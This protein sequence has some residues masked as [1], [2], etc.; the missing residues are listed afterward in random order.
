M[1][2]FLLRGMLEESDYPYLA[3]YEEEWIDAHGDTKSFDEMGKIHLQNCYRMLKKQ[4]RA[5]ERGFF[6]KGIAY[7]ESQYDEIVSM[8]TALYNKKVKE[9]VEYLKITD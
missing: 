5:I 9:L 2:E 3:A 8:T 7:E 1:N 4:K 6:L